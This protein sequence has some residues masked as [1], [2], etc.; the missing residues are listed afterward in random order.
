MTKRVREILKERVKSARSGKIWYLL[1]KDKVR[2]LWD[3]IRAEMGWQDDRIYCPYIC[4]HHTTASRMVSGGV[5][6]VMVM[7]FM[8]HSQWVTTLGYAHLAPSDL[9][10]CVDVLEKDKTET[11]VI[12]LTAQRAG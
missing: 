9:D 6:L 10:V 12:D 7:K 1:T 5:S 2:N 8:G 3:T 11:N 4:R